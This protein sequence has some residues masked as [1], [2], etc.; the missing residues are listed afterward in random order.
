VLDETDDRGITFVLLMLT[1]CGSATLLDDV[2]GVV[3]DCTTD[4]WSDE[5]WKS[6][7]WFFLLVRVLSVMAMSRTSRWPNAGLYGLRADAQH[8]FFHNLIS[9]GPNNIDLL[10]IC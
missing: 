7:M 3:S 5:S 9:L 4:D 10:S 2:K 8:T 1:G 6:A